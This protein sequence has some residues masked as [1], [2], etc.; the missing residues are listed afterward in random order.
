MNSHKNCLFLIISK[1]YLPTWQPQVEGQCR[2]WRTLCRPNSCLLAPACF[3]FLIP[4]RLSSGCVPPLPLFR[5]L[6]SIRFSL[7]VP[8][9][10]ARGELYTHLHVHSRD[11][12]DGVLGVRGFGLQRRRCFLASQQVDCGGAG[13]LKL[14]LLW[15]WL[16][17]QTP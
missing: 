15:W 9:H 17:I 1:Y 7:P 4:E 14:L 6:E 11:V 10:P 8:Q 2:T 12:E 5:P 16:V 3:D 13:W